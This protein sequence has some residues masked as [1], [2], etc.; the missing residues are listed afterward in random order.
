MKDFMKIRPYCRETGFPEKT[1]R[2]LCDS[3]LG[4]RFARRTGDAV[5][6]HWVIDTKKFKAMWE[7]EE[8]RN[9]L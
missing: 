6:S 3:H 9:V 4:H 2:K 5:N 7:R 1:L 8:F